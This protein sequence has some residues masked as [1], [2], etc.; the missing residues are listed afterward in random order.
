MVVN[1]LKINL[2][3]AN[4]HHNLFFTFQKPISPLSCFQHNGIPAEAKAKSQAEKPEIIFKTRDDSCPTR[5][6][7]A[8]RLTLPR[9][10]PPG[11]KQTSHH[12]EEK[13]D[14]FDGKICGH[15]AASCPH[16]ACL[17]PV[18]TSFSISRL[19]LRLIFSFY[20]KTI[21][22]CQQRKSGHPRFSLFFNFPFPSALFFS[23]LSTLSTLSILC[24][25]QALKP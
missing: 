17:P 2:K 25:P 3:F 23:T 21:F 15:F 8:S 19:I 1:R 16:A 6:A 9:L 5:P 10:S 18:L 24:P 12:P 4:L 11:D 20:I 14:N 7:L 13:T 22:P